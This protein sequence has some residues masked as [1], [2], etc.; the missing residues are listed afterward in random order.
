M[1]VREGM[2]P[3]ILG[4]AVTT[5]GLAIRAA[6]PVLGWGIAGFGLAHV[7]L[8]AIDLVEHNTLRFQEEF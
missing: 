5:A 8:G 2:V 1:T 4:A 7:L 6:N 3:T